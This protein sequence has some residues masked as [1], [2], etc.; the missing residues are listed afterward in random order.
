MSRATGRSASRCPRSRSTASAISGKEGREAHVIVLR[1]AGIVAAVAL[2][3]WIMESG[4]VL[5]N[6]TVTRV[7]FLRATLSNY[8]VPLLDVVCHERHPQ[9][10]VLRGAAQLQA[11]LQR[12]ADAL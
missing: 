5:A 11:L 1:A 6:Q 4:R 7:H 9:P 12:E 2:R 8:K 10:G 3:F